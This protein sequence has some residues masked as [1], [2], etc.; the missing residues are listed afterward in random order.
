MMRMR[1]DGLGVQKFN[2][3]LAI[4]FFIFF[5]ILMFCLMYFVFVSNIV[6]PC[7]SIFNLHSSFV[8]LIFI[9]Y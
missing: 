7:Q 3:Q 8:M 1:S 2:F 9:Y 4:L 5:R 6:L